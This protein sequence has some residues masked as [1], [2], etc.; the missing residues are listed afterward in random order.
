[1]NN[2]QSI[3]MQLELELLAPATRSNYQRLDALLADDFLETGASGQTICKADVLAH[4]PQEQ[5]LGFIASQMQAQLLSPT[6]VLVTYVASRHDADQTVVSK[7]SSVWV[8]QADHWQMRYH[9]GTLADNR[10]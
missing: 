4:L 5:G 8:K 6:V 2:S 3:V 7:R 10:Q 9:Q 1:M